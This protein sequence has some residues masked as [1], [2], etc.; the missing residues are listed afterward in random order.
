[1]LCIHRE[2]Q[3]LKRRVGIKDRRHAGILQEILE[4][5]CLLT[6]SMKQSSSGEV[7]LRLLAPISLSLGK[8][9]GFFMIS[10]AEDVLLS[11]N[12]LSLLN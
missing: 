2:L 5:S 10:L 1:M 11:L 12:F 3:P 6:L 4:G 8:L 9:E 7:S